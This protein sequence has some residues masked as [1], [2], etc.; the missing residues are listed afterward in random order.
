MAAALDGD[1]TSQVADLLGTG[2][3]DLLADAVQRVPPLRL[4]DAFAGYACTDTAEAARALVET[5]LAD[6]A[7]E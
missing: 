4:R 6:P 2:N 5:G 1:S 7:A 3:L